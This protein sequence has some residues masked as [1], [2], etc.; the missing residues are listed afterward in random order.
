MVALRFIIYIFNQNIHLNHL[1]QMCG[2]VLQQYAPNS[3]IPFFVQLSSY[4]LVVHVLSTQDIQLA[5]LALDSFLL[6]QLKVKK[7]KEKKEFYNI[8]TY[9]MSTFSLCFYRS[10]SWHNIYF[11]PSP[12]KDS[13]L[14]FP[15]PFCSG[16]SL[17]K[18]LKGPLYFPFI[19]Q[20]KVFDL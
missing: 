11:C 14:L 10:K 4:I 16:F 20:L 15:L 2:R 6:K 12:G 9:S 7:K 17:Q 1:I 3:F 5:F 13:I 8:V 19:Q 18:K